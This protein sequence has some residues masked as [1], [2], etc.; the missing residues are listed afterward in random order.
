MMLPGTRIALRPL[1]VPG[2]VVPLAGSL[3]GLGTGLAAFIGSLVCAS[4]VIAL[5]WVIYRLL[6]A[7][8][9]LAAVA[10]RGTRRLFACIRQ[11]RARYSQQESVT[12][13]QRNG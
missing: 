8:A 1:R 9:L 13:L 12:C 4:G 2:S 3:I 5:A 10:Q 7:L 11:V 6:V